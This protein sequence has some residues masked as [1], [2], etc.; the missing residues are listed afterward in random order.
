[1]SCG[2]VLS[3]IVVVV[4]GRLRLLSLLYCVIG[5]ILLQLTEA[6]STLFDYYNKR[7]TIELQQ[8]GKKLAADY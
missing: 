5:V 7:E 2:T 3:Y 8:G 1:L 6:A 4:M